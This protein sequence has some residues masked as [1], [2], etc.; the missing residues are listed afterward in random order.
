MRKKC[1]T[2]NLGICM[3]VVMMTFA[4]CVLEVADEVFNTFQKILND[5]EIMEQ[6]PHLKCKNHCNTGTM[7]MG[8]YGG[9]QREN[10]AKE[11]RQGFIPQT[12]FTIYSKINPKRAWKDKGREGRFPSQEPATT[13]YWLLHSGITKD[14]NCVVVVV[15]RPSS[16]LC[17]H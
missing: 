16:V 14:V 13:G 17:I 11:H 6:L 5:G 9:A 8:Y 2:T 3:V 7:A 12:A 15:R 1:T 10:K 4:I